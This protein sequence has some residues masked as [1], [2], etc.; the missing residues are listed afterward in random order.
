[1]LFRSSGSKYV[2][3]VGEWKT[4]YEEPS[5][6]NLKYPR[7]QGSPQ[8]YDYRYELNFKVQ[9]KPVVINFAL[10]YGNSVRDPIDPGWWRYDNIINSDVLLVHDLDSSERRVTMQALNFLRALKKEQGVQTSKILVLSD[11]MYR[12][13]KARKGFSD[14]GVEVIERNRNAQYGCS[15]HSMAREGMVVLKVSN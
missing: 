6:P 1:M 15:C 2:S 14:L 13:I 9:G 3:E 4:T 5:L 12:Q 11:K 7:P 8:T 10:G